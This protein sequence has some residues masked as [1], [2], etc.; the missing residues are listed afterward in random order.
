MP[1]LTISEKKFTV[2]F[3]ISFVSENQFPMACLSYPSIKKIV[4]LTHITDSLK[5][6]TAAVGDASS[7]S[8]VERAKPT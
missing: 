5:N 7:S 2:S 4:Y 8:P 3:I 6:V 1:G